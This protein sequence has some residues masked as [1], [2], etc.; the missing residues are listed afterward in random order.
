MGLE[1]Y[2]EKVHTKYK[3]KKQKGTP[4]NSRITEELEAIKA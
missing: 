2:G 1:I 4:L 3:R